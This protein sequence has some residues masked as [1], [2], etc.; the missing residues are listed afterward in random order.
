M[1]TIC[2]ADLNCRIS[3]LVDGF[4]TQNRQYVFVQDRAS[5]PGGHAEI[6]VA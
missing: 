1:Y 6:A 4:K 2:I 3:D 5:E